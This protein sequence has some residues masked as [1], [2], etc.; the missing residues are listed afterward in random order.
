MAAWGAIIS[1]ALTAGAQGAATVAN[2]LGQKDQ[3]RYNT[4]MQEKAWEREDA[5]AQ[6]RKADLS[7]AGL[8]PVLAAGSAATTMA[9]IRLEA[10]QLDTAAI[11]NAG[12]TVTDSMMQALAMKQGAASITKTAAET[13]NIQAQQ[14]KTEVETEFMKENNPTVIE[15]NKIARDVA[16][17]TKPATVQRAFQEVK[18]VNLDNANKIID[19]K[20]KNLHVTNAEIDI[21]KNRISV[22]AARMG[23]PEKALDIVSKKIAL[24]LK[25]NELENAQF[26]TDFYHSR[27]LPRNFSFGVGQPAVGIGAMTKKMMDDQR[28]A[29]EYKDYY[30]YL[31]SKGG[32]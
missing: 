25:E 32:K 8:S 31:K 11:A 4:K 9:P 21:V 24:D 10:P 22:T 3:N 19:N 26:D 12:K 16:N 28:K 20:I 30:K 17:A 14:T 2:Y 18:G 5:A 23:I 15:A 7:A 27:G 13:A 1:G 6:R 29:R